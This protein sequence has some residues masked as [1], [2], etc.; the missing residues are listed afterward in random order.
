M[1]D[2]N[3]NPPQELTEIPYVSEGALL[4]PKEAFEGGRETML[5]EGRLM[6]R[7]E[8]SMSVV[9]Q[10]ELSRVLEIDWEVVR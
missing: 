9:R 4:T 8:V 7:R 6:K 2:N 5:L 10:H 1:T 3:T